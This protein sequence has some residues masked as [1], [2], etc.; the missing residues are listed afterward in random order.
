LLDLSV[1]LA[2]S[3]SEVI[4]VEI[5]T[6]D[7]TAGGRHLA[8]L[9]GVAQSTLPSGMAWASERVY[10][11]TH[12][13]THVDAPFHYSPT[14]NGAPA[15]TID[16]LPLEWFLGP[17]VC[18]HANGQDPSELIDQAEFLRAEE[19]IGH[20]VK[21]PEIVLFNTGAAR[22]YGSPGYNHC[23]R[24]ISPE[25]I[26]MLCDREVKVIGTDAWSIDPPLVR[27]GGA[28]H[29]PVWAAHY[30]GRSREFCAIERLCNLDLLP[31]QGFWISCF[32]VKVHRGSGAWIRAV[33]LF[34]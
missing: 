27:M 11:G 30:V 2:P 23:G 24:G 16:E 10:A 19:R 32:P 15:R 14:C 33:A 25:V 9:V 1:S 34:Y 6:M 7:H 4:P 31:E 28:T 8:E 5:E 17:G 26:E 20:R 21:F 12:S 29:K 18:I 3:P 22:H 13:G